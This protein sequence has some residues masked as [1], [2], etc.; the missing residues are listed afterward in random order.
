MQPTSDGYRTIA[1][2]INV[3]LALSCDHAAGALNTIAAARPAPIRIFLVMI[4]LAWWNWL[5]PEPGAD[6]E[7]TT[8]GVIKFLQARYLHGEAAGLGFS[9]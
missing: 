5:A 1:F 3:W 8:A 2:L 9:C 6:G 4:Y 7:G